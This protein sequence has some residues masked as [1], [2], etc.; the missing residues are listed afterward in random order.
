[1]PG[2]VDQVPMVARFLQAEGA[3]RQFSSVWTEDALRRLDAFGL[4]IEDIRIARLGGRIAGVIALW[5]QTAYKQAIVRGYSGW[6][7]AVAPLTKLPRVGEQVRSAYASLVCVANDD[8]VLFAR[9]LREV[10]NL[11]QRRR[12]HYLL[13][14]LDTRDP[15]L[16]I[17]LAYTHVAYPSRFYLGN[18][19]NGS[20]GDRQHEQLD[21][22]PA[23]VD[24]ATL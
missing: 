18:W 13:V 10:Y 23:Y 17:P 12:F 20:N 14:G 2:T 3:R 15:L 19:T 24:I 6:L 16:R 5:D 8:P 1:V 7:K 11:A 9:L 4:R 22:R 21:D